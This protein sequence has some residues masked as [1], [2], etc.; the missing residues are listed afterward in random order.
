VI[1]EWLSRYVGGSEKSTVRGAHL[2]AIGGLLS[3]R[4]ASGNSHKLGTVCATC[5]NGWMSDLETAF[6]SLLPRLEANMSPKQ[7]SKAERHTI[8]LWIV[9]T[10]IIVH[11]SSNYR[12][13][14]PASVPRALSR[15]MTVTA[16]IKV[17]GGSV[18]LEK[19]IRWGQSNIGAAVIQRSDV[20][21]YDWRQSTFVFV[22]S[23]RDI[24]IGFGWHGLS[25]DDFELV[26]SGN[27]TH[28]I[29]PHPKPAIR[30]RVL[31]DVVLATTEIGLRRRHT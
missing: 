17:F 1:P 24:F 9:K 4:K 12:I 27:S 6:G 2:S 20:E 3:E 7:F 22:L 29:Y 30:P 11:Y 21:D 18:P 25:Q 15:D 16:G 13:I 26:Y 19:T 5:N 8:A 31:E 23:I 14:L 10:G 28:W